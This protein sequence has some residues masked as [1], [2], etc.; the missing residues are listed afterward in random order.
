M[1]EQIRMEFHGFLQSWYTDDFSTAGAGANLLPFIKHI[2]ELGPS[3][4]LYL[5]SENHNF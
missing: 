5:E 1:V 2:Q 3:R 4:G